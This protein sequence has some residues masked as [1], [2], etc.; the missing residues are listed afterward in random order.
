MSSELKQQEPIP[1]QPKEA[2]EQPKEAPEDVKN[3]DPLTGDESDAEVAKRL[4]SII[5]SANERLKPLIGTL[6]THR[7]PLVLPLT[8]RR[9]DEET[10]RQGQ[11]RQRKGRSG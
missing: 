10:S 9:D 8:S 2:P 11:A 5:D 4:T 7:T 3:P 6:P 1:E